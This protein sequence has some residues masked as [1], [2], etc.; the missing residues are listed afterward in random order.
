MVCVCE[1]AV[2]CRAVHGYVI[3]LLLAANAGT[4]SAG[5]ADPVKFP[6][7][8]ERPR[9][10]E[11]AA[12]AVSGDLAQVVI[13]LNNLAHSNYGLTVS[14]ATNEVWTN[15]DFTNV[16]ACGSVTCTGTI[17]SIIVS[18]CHVLHLGWSVT[19][20]AIVI[21]Q[22]QCD[23]ERSS[24]TALIDSARLCR[25]W[26]SSEY[27]PRDK[28]EAAKLALKA[29]MRRVDIERLLGKPDRVAV[30]LSVER[31]DVAEAGMRDGKSRRYA[32]EYKLDAGCVLEIH[33][34]SMGG[35]AMNDESS[36]VGLRK[37]MLGIPQGDG[38]EY[39]WNF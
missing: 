21:S 18:V 20:D 13:Q 33:Y 2:L 12:G 36:W 24:L 14:L 6:R 38:K 34:R 27:S 4:S 19:N 26:K 7:V 11:I 37:S 16:M 5:Q 17:D 25:I 10:M 8:H 23:S 1:T 3:L 29:G 31:A 30:A 9:S 15:P 28:Y 32:C 39:H 35:A 22:Q